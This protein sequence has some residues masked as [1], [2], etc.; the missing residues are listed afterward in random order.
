[1]NWTTR[2]NTVWNFKMESWRWQIWLTIVG[3]NGMDWCLKWQAPSVPLWFDA[4]CEELWRTWAKK[5]SCELCSKKLHGPCENRCSWTP[6]LGFLI[7]YGSW[8]STQLIKI[9]IYKIT[10]EKKKPLLSILFHKCQLIYIL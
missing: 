1:M 8:K 10:V 2:N 9:S 3:I 6:I 7:E 4:W 5:W